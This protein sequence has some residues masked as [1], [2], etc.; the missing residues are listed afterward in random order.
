M[1]VLKKH[2]MIDSKK[3]KR[4]IA[5]LLLWGILIL[6][7]AISLW[8]LQNSVG[9]F[10]VSEMFPYVAVLSSITGCISFLYLSRSDRG[11]ET[12][13]NDDLMYSESLRKSMDSPKKQ[14]KNPKEG[15]VNTSGSI[16]EKDVDDENT[17][18]EIKH[19]F[20]A[21]E[22][23]INNEIK[24]L[25]RRATV[26]LSWGVVLSSAALLFFF[27]L[28]YN[29]EIGKNL[30]QVFLHFV[31]RLGLV[32]FVE[33]LAYFFLRLYKTSLVSIQYY[34]NELTNIETKKI[35]AIV[36]IKH[37]DEAKIWQTVESLLKVERNVL[38]KG[39]ETTIQMEMLKM[40]NEYDN[41]MI[42]SM[43]SMLEKLID[44]VSV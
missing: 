33:L 38:L 36:A 30:E 22:E 1:L 16:H 12:K 27:F 13:I 44:K 6:A 17:A 8:K 21:S 23:R 42:N 11:K 35:A 34:H 39:K 31:P 40:Q 43:K 41:K 20:L 9:N 10:D 18:N 15:R 5:A 25:K 32:V 2:N 28:I 19:S 4:L 29:E 24:N 7:S 37:C 26:N 3:N 14:D